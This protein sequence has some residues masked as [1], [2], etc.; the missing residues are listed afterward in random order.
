M[1]REF[2]QRSRDL[3]A[4]MK[5]IVSPASTSSSKILRADS[6]PLEFKPARNFSETNS[7]LSAACSFAN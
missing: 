1:V 2:Q 3:G 6:Q 7:L 4:L 5:A